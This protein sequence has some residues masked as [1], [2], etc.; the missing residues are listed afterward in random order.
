MRVLIATDSFPPGCGGSGWSTCELAHGLRARGHDLTIVHVRPGHRDGERDYEGFLVRE[1]GAA[2]P[3]VPF[4]RNYFKNERLTARLRP[5]L[6]RLIADMRVEIVHAQH[7]LTI[8]AAVAAAADAGVRSVA[9]IRD[10]WPV[11]YWSDLIHDRASESLCPGCSG[12]MMRRCIRPRAGAAWPL[13]LPMIPYMQANLRRKQHALA[14]ADRVIAVSSTIAAD[15]GVRAPLLSRDRIVTIPNPVDIEAV[16]SAARAQPRRLD[17]PY[18]VYV[19]KLAPNKGTSRLL[20]AVDRSQ[21]DWPLVVIGDGPD[22]PLVERWARTSARDIRLTGWLPREQALGWMA[23]ASLLIFPSQG[24]ESLSRVLLEG[25]ALGL[26]MA[27]MDTGGTRDIIIAGQTGLLSSTAAGLG[28][29]V[30]RLA[31]DRALAARLGR[32]AKAHVEATFAAERVVG[33]VEGVYRELVA[34][35]AQD[36]R[37]TGLSQERS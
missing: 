14:R 29:D 2:A 32:G 22:R 26:P 17:G 31:H 19:G 33:R 3:D 12:R 24:P 27:A 16:R 13:A 28:D 10:Y 5:T 23:G 34:R 1:I 8:P 9:T 35:R 7:V 20:A 36:Q 25:G 18:A 21:L 30:A 11:C 6:A 37:K 15:L 4:I